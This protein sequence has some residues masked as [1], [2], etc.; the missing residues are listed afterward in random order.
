MTADATPAS[1]ADP[2]AERMAEIEGMVNEQANDPGL[3]FVP[4][5]ITEDILQRALRRLHV[6]IEGKSEAECAVD[7]LRV[8]DTVFDST[9]G[10]QTP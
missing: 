3:W 5:T 4:Q 9:E 7:A 8:L 1:A 10:K 2:R 6:A